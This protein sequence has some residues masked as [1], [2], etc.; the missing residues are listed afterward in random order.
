MTVRSEVGV[1]IVRGENKGEFICNV[2]NNGVTGGGGG[3]GGNWTASAVVS[4]FHRRACTCWDGLSRVQ[5]LSCGAG[6]PEL[7]LS[8]F[9]S[10]LTP[11]THTHTHYLT[12]L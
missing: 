5:G 12:Y 6:C 3:G 7:S 11:H 1:S 10:H 9:L 2:G 4:V 8:L